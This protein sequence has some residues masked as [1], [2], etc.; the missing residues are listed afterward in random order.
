MAVDKH[1][2]EKRIYLLLRKYLGYYIISRK[3]SKTFDVFQLR[4][5]TAGESHHFNQVVLTPQQA[6]D[7]LPNELHLKLR[8]TFSLCTL[9]EENKEREPGYWV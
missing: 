6:S 9:K 3:P 7:L 4:Q 1:E 8:Y 2:T 5:E